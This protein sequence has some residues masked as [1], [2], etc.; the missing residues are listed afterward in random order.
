MRL[1]APLRYEFPLDSLITRF[2]FHHDL[3]AG[4][5]LAELLADALAM[6]WPESDQNS[7]ER[8]DLLVPVPLHDKRLRERGFNQALELAK[9]IAPRLGLPIDHTALGRRRAT[10]AQSELAAKARRRNVHDAFI[11]EPTRVTDCH[12]LLIDDVATTTATAEE[13]ARALKVAGARS[14]SVGVIAR[15][16]SPKR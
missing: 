5:L 7:T 4:L 16:P 12:I 8:P 6:T 2:K 10:Q 14:V 1:I 13:C 15:A 9:R 3:A 11:A